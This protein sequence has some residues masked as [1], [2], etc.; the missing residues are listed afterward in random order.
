MSLSTLVKVAAVAATIAVTAGTASGAFAAPFL[1]GTIKWGGPVRAH[2]DWFSFVTNN[3]WSGEHVTIDGQWGNFYHVSI[4]GPD[5]WV[6]RNEVHV[7]FGGPG[8]GF[9]GP[10]ACFFGPF[11]S[12]CV[13]P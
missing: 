11:G 2:H 9:G 8:W 7:N 13:S 12:F 4:P 10:K 1:H 6:P 3:V 5:G